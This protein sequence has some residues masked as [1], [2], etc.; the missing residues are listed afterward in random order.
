MRLRIW[1]SLPRA[2]QGSL[3][4]HRWMVGMMVSN[5][6]SSRRVE[7]PSCDPTQLLIERCYMIV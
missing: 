5:G 3:L 2:S 4:L 1:R 6:L 7:N